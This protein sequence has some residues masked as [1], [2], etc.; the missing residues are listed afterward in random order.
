MALMGQALNGLDDFDEESD[1]EDLFKPVG[2]RK[3]NQD[4]SAADKRQV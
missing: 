3:N 1:D 2:A 4:A